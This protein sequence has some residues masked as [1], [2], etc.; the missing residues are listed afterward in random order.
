MPRLHSLRLFAWSRLSLTDSVRLR[1]SCFSMS[2]VDQGCRCASLCHCQVSSPPRHLPRLSVA[3]LHEALDGMFASSPAFLDIPKRLFL[4]MMTADAIDICPSARQSVRIKQDRVISRNFNLLEILVGQSRSGIDIIPC[5]SG[6]R[7]W[8]SDLSG[9]LS[10]SGCLYSIFENSRSPGSKSR[11]RQVGD[12]PERSLGG[13]RQI[14]PAA[15]AA[16]VIGHS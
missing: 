5:N 4:V 16:T 6:Y 12:R 9:G 2:C 11:S 1:D 3:S 8:S 7:H 15:S 14:V 13:K 10:V